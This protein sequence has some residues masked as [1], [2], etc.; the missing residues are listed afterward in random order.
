MR[1]LK[2]AEIWKKILGRGPE[3]TNV[4]EDLT[5]SIIKGIYG[6]DMMMEAMPDVHICQ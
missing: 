2:L 5:A 4:S 6:P 1:H 3:R